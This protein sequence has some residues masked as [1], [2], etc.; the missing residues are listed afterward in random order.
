MTEIIRRMKVFLTRLQ[1]EKKIV[2]RD[3]ATRNI[4]VDKNGDWYVIDFGK[5]KKIEIGDESTV[6]SEKADFAMA[7]SSIRQLFAKI[8]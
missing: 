6:M 3:L 8:Y 4:M 7:E 2:H 5:A 1:E